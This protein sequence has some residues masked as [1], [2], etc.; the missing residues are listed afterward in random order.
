MALSANA[1]FAYDYFR[2]NGMSDVAAAGLVGTLM[3]ESGQGLD[4]SSYNPNDPGGAYGILQATG[5]SGRAQSLAGYQDANAKSE[6]ERQLSYVLNEMRGSE[7][8][9]GG[10]FGNAKSLEDATAAGLAYLRPADQAVGGENYN[11]RLNY[12]RGVLSASGTAPAPGSAASGPTYNRVDLGGYVSPGK[13]I[14]G[15]NDQFTERLSYALGAMP[16]DVRKSFMITSGFRTPEQQQKLWDASDKTGHMVARPGHSQ[17]GMGNAFDIGAGAA[18]DWLHQHGAEYGLKFPMSYEPWHIETAETRGGQ[19]F[20]APWAGGGTQVAGVMNA[21]GAA[22]EA[23]IQTANATEAGTQAFNEAFAAQ[24]QA[25]DAGKAQQAQQAA[26]AAQQT[27]QQAQQQR[28]QPGPGNP[29]QDS[30]ASMMASLLDKKRIARA[31][32]VPGVLSAWSA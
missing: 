14:T 18:R 19:A 29:S 9:A 16:E 10:M 23:P 32:P 7:A 4:T 13:S 15:A 12:A 11:R 22:P 24:Q 1:Q 2:R 8:K 26:Q 31:G 28:L 3:G 17:H 21:Q 20:N 6:L 25:D 5:G 30:A 27:A